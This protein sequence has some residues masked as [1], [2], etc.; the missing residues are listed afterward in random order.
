MH[1]PVILLTTVLLVSVVLLSGVILGAAALLFTNIL[2]S[3]GLA[4]SVTVVV[5]GSVVLEITTSRWEPLIISMSVSYD[6]EG[7]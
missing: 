4:E 6:S 1:W 3:L 2:F 7:I 5:D